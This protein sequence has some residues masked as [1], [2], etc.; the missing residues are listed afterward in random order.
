MKL[1]DLKGSAFKCPI[2]GCE[3][4]RTAEEFIRSDWLFT[5]VTVEQVAYSHCP[6]HGLLPFE[7]IKNYESE[8]SEEDSQTVS[9][10][11][12]NVISISK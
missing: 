5:P 11:K 7:Y 9:N 1:Q 8:S 12:G 6:D 4:V 3:F 2:K 10:P